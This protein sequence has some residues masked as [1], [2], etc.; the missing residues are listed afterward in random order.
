MAPFEAARQSDALPGNDAVKAQR[1]KTAGNVHRAAPAR[2]QLETIRPPRGGGVEPH[3][4]GTA[5]ERRYI[6]GQLHK[7]HRRR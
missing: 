7:F 3:G 1:S 4:L 5:R 6:G 2:L